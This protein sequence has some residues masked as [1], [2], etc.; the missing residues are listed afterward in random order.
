MGEECGESNVTDSHPTHIGE[1]SFN[2]EWGQ[3]GGTSRR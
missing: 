1:Q 3:L 2:F